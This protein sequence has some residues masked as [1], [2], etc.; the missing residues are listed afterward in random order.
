MEDIVSKI[1][2]EIMGRSNVFE[3]RTKWTKDEYNIYNEN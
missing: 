3:E 2:Q 1:Q